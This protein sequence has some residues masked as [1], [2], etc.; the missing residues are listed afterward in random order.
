MG[1]ILVKDDEDGNAVDIPVNIVDA[2]WRSK[3]DYLRAH[4]ELLR[5]DAIAPL[6]D[7]V[8]VVQASPEMH[9]SKGACI[10]EKVIKLPYVLTIS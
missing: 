6:R 4:Y 3:E 1:E 7:A 5:E 2:A 10:Y 9:D 8:A